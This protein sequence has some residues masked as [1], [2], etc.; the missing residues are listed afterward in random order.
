MNKYMNVLAYIMK[1]MLM[2]GIEDYRN[3]S[4]KQ[5]LQTQWDSGVVSSGKC[6][7]HSEHFQVCRS[8]EMHQQHNSGL[9]VCWNAPET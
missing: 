2:E 4:E 7:G 9:Q 3:L 8:A 5:H 6:T 1:T